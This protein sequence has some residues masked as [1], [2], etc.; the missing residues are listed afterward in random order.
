MIEVAIMPVVLGCGVK[1]L[2][3]GKDGSHGWKLIKT[4]DDTRSHD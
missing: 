4:L 2:A 3:D 1:M